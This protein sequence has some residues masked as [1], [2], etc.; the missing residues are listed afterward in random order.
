MEISSSSYSNSENIICALRGKNLNRILQS[1]N[2]LQF[3]QE[4][5]LKNGTFIFMFFDIFCCIRVNQ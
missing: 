4:L 1:L 3:F 5:E 2:L